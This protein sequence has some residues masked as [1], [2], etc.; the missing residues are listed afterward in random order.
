MEKKRFGRTKEARALQA[1]GAPHYYSVH[2]QLQRCFDFPPSF[3]PDS[4]LS[5]PKVTSYAPAWLS[6]PS[7]GAS[8]FTRNSARNPVEDLRNGTKP[9][10]TSAPRTIAK[11]G[12]EVFTV[13]D[14]EIRWSDLARL[15][16]QWQQQARQQTDSAAN[17]AEE[18]SR[19]E[20]YKVG[21]SCSGGNSW[22]I[23]Q[24]T[25]LRL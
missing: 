9:T 14:N 15:K 7:L 13:V 1:L 2:Q 18:N 25:T 19:D 5:M 3:A 8:V 4:P 11:R 21:R 23:S 12:T 6:R 20:P 24:L 17:H 10:P 22:V 16:D